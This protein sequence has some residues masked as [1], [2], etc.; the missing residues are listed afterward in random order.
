[1]GKYLSQTMLR[2]DVLENLTLLMVAGAGNALKADETHHKLTEF[3]L[4]VISNPSLR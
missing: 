4:K 1:M 3:M 2:K